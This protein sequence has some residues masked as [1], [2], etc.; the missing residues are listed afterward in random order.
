MITLSEKTYHL[1]L[2]ADEIHIIQ[3]ALC[4][5]LMHT[6][7]PAFAEQYIEVHRSISDK[8]RNAQ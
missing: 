7:V 1:E 2:T 5:A 4:E 6:R 8:W 3:N